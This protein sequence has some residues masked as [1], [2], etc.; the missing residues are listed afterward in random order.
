M[1]LLLKR[2]LSFL[3]SPVVQVIIERSLQ[4]DVASLH[5]FEGAVVLY[6]KVAEATQL[7]EQIESLSMLLEP[8]PGEFMDA[9]FNIYQGAFKN[10]FL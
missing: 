3:A 4:E 10:S 6:T 5:F 8:Y 9:D 7:M 1:D 2:L